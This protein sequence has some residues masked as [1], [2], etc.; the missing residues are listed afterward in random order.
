MANRSNNRGWMLTALALIS[1]WG[2]GCITTP[3]TPDPLRIG[4]TADYPP[5]VMMQDGRLAG[6]EMEMAVLLGRDLGR[7]LEFVPVRWRNQI[8]SLAD[9][10]TDIIMSGLTVTRKR[11]MRVAFAEPYVRNSVM[12]MVRAGDAD[13][14][15]SEEDVRS[16]AGTIG[17]QSGTSGDV[18][19]R[20]NCPLARIIRV[21]DPEQAVYE[22]DRKRIDLFLHDGHSIAWLASQNEGSMR[23][24]WIP[25]TEEYLAWAVRRND[26]DLLMEVNSVLRTWKA[27]GRLEILLARWLPYANQVQVPIGTI[28]DLAPLADESL[29]SR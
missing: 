8:D 1:T 18:F 21:A 5:L 27:D 25:L 24:I 10:Q 9:G 12:G 13:A 14:I 22:L 23:G 11:Q 16:F 4:L 17:V 3:D 28:P 29:L 6:L 20:A 15:R 2:S 7:P 19:A 26:A